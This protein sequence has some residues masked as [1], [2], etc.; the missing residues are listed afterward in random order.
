MIGLLMITLGR[1]K[2]EGCESYVTQ[3]VLNDR[4]NP[5]CTTADNNLFDFLNSTNAVFRLSRWQAPNGVPPS[6]L[7]QP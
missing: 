6:W 5:Y 7:D 4:R 3:A 2:G 1:M